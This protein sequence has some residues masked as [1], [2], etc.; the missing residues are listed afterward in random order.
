MLPN[1]CHAEP[2]LRR[3]DITRARTLEDVVRLSL[4]ISRLTKTNDDHGTEDSAGANHSSELIRAVEGD[5]VDRLQLDGVG[6]L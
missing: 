4:I 1:P 5:E 6:A 2:T 3:L